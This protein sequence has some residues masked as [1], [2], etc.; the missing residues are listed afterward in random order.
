[1]ERVC[2][3]GRR[4]AQPTQSTTLRH[5]S[6]LDTVVGKDETKEEHTLLIGSLYNLLVERDSDGLGLRTMWN[7]PK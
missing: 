6:W 5:K 4:I 2:L 7:H 1:M 3:L